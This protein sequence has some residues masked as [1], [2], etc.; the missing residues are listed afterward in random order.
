MKLSRRQA[1]TVLAGSVAAGLVPNLHIPTAP[2]TWP[3]GM[4]KRFRGTYHLHTKEL[5]FFDP[6]A[7]DGTGGAE[8]DDGGD[9]PVGH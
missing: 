8:N 7:A 5:T 9:F 6:D 4:G 2:V 3:V 1:L